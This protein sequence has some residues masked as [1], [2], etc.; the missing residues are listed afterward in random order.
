MFL[1]NMLLLLCSNT[2]LFWFTKLV[3]SDEKV[4]E[5]WMEELTEE[6]EWIKSHKCTR[7]GLFYDISC[8][9]Q[10]VLKLDMDGIRPG[11]MLNYGSDLPRW[12]TAKVSLLISSMFIFLKK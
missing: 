7:C 2:N 9:C 5:T 6:L 4:K 10:Q 8:D 1:F 12:K 11:G 3:L